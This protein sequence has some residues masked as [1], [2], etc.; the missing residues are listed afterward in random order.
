M[1]LSLNTKK[2]TFVRAFTLTIH[3]FETRLSK[4]SG[5]IHPEHPNKNITQISHT[6]LLPSDL[7]LKTG[8]LFKPL[9]ILAFLF[10][11]SFSPHKTLR[12]HS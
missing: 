4:M 1:N 9:T 2:N 11:K 8:L 6:N 7:G 3:H 10:F 12:V 5:K